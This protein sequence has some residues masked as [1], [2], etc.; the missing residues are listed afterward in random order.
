MSSIPQAYFI[1]YGTPSKKM[2][3]VTVFLVIQKTM[4]EQQ[5]RFAIE[6]A[7]LGN[8]TQSAKN[9]GYSEA[10]A[11][12]QGQRLLK[13]AEVASRISEIK[14]QMAEDLRSKMVQQASTAFKVLVGI[15]NDESAKDA[16]RIKCAID[17]MDRA[18]YVAQQKVEVSAN[19]SEKLDSVFN[20]LGGKG[21]KE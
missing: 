15:M 18:G 17:V 7:R 21:L 6:Y 5:E 16:D 20:Q 8:A 2:V 14:A 10:T 11:Y 4:T 13:N 12:S 9:A 3:Q 1:F 19:L